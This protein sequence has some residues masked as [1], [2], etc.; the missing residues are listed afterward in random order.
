MVSTRHTL[1]LVNA[2]GTTGDLLGLAGEI[3]A[4]VER[5]FGVRLEREPVVLTT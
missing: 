4:E 2:G 5:R 3:Q 1:A